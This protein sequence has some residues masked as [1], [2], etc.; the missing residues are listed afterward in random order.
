MCLI[1]I[2]GRRLQ[3]Q[4]NDVMTASARGLPDRTRRGA[5]NGNG[6]PRWGVRFLIHS[7]GGERRQYCVRGHG[8]RQ[9]RCCKGTS[10]LIDGAMPFGAGFAG[11]Q[12]VQGAQRGQGTACQGV[13]CANL[14]SNRQQGIVSK[15]CRAVAVG[16]H[17]SMGRVNSFQWPEVESLSIVAVECCQQWLRT[18]KLGARVVFVSRADLPGLVIP[19]KSERLA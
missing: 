4:R 2:M 3:V 10:G 12:A 8:S 14:T 5:A 15:Q 1:E 6:V 13:P 17:R 16:C 9:D 18:P 7:L 11:G 19:S